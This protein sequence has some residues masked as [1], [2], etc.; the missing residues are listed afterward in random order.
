MAIERMRS[1]WL[2]APRGVARNV[3]DRLAAMG[4]AH[5]A[6]CGVGG[7][8]DWQ[9]LGVA[10]VFPDVAEVERHVQRFQETCDAL[11][12][13]LRTK[14]D[15]L[16][17]FITTPVEV[18][19][20]QV[21]AALD[22][23][24]VAELSRRARKRVRER[25]R[26]TASLQKARERLQALDSLRGYDGLVPAAS[27][28]G[29]VAAFLGMMQ[30]LRVGQLRA[31]ERLPETAVVEAGAPGGRLAVVQ[32][33]CL[34]EDAE[35]FAQLLRQYGFE[36]IEGEEEM[37]PAAEYLSHRRAEAAELERRV[38][39]AR[40]ALVEMAK[41]EL[42]DVE[43]ALGY[44]E[45]RLRIA[46]AAG[47][48]AESKR[49]TVTHVYVRERDLDGFRGTLAAD[50]PDVGIQ[51]E[52]PKPGDPVPVSLRNPKLFAP[53]QFLIS[54]IGMP[55][56][57]TFDPTVIVFLNFTLFFG[58]CLGDA[59]YGVGLMLL[60]GLLA[61][62]YR[63]Y[64]GLRHLFTLL[65]YAGVPTF[66]VGVLT[67]SWAGSLLSPTWLGAPNPFLSASNPLVVFAGRLTLFDMLDRLMLAL[68]L[69]LMLGVANQLLGMLCL[70]YRRYLAGDRLGAVLDSIFWFVALPAGI[71]LAATLF[72]QVPIPAKKAAQVCLGL[73][74]IGLVLTQGRRE[75]S[76]FG[77]I[78]VGI[79]SLYGVA[80]TY[81]FSSF[82]NDVLSYSRLLALGLATTIIGI[83][84][85]ILANMA[86]FTGIRAVNIILAAVILVGGHLTNFFLNVLGAFVHSVRLVFVEFFGRFY[87]AGAPAF[88][89]IGTW[90][91]R[92]RVTDRHTLWSD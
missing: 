66:I 60:G 37:I 39:E 49:L 23:I 58:I 56:Y 59:V 86:R 21:R 19:E 82:L 53:A 34:R 3:L 48:M 80:G 25:E 81:G 61:R 57:N 87:E 67:G 52:E 1:V 55:G 15:F 50:L 43:M 24:D 26:L 89:P 7:E 78:G 41:V 73:G 70:S 33:A 38:G 76:V 85:N 84:F 54:M 75:K 29:P 30:G 22:R 12:P 11:S 18:S 47:L 36:E 20:A 63:E 13:F 69:A 92:I 42:R 14:R 9:H 64:T 68:V 77:K 40:A 4:T 35:E 71:V 17:N 90:S 91:G 79:V 51:V 2:F 45:E 46:R 88:A 27:G 28:R 32:A 6:D 62:K 74:A 65:A 16:G 31:D 10:R 72:V 8:K 5:V 44:W 83:A